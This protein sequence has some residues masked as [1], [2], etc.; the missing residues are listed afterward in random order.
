MLAGSTG[1][2]AQFASRSSRSPWNKPQSISSRCDPFSKRYF[3]PVTVPAAPR[4]L[5]LMLTERSPLELQAFLDRD[6]TAFAGAPGLALQS[7]QTQ[8]ALKRP[9]RTSRQAPRLRAPTLA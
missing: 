5:N 8:L 2:R 4:K 1:N 9:S 6:R 7:K 3:D